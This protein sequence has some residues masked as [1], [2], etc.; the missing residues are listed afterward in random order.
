MMRYNQHAACMPGAEKNKTMKKTKTRGLFAGGSDPLQGK[1]QEEMEVGQVGLSE[2]QFESKF[3]LQDDEE[4]ATYPSLQDRCKEM[5]AAKQDLMDDLILRSL[6][7]CA[8][9]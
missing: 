6:S 5:E 3:P 1:V 7:L 9:D 8:L 2:D 4:I